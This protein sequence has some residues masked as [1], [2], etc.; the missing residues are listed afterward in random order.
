V[1]EQKDGLRDDEHAGGSD[2][3]PMHWRRTSVEA[4]W[5][6]R[7]LRTSTCARSTKVV[8]PPWKRVSLCLVVAIN[9]GAAVRA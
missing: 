8:E 2:Q 3:G 9:T 1:Q 7:D 6:V 4:L 5:A